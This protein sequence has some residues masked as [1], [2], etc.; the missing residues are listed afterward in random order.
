MLRGTGFASKPVGCLREKPTAVSLGDEPPHH[1]IDIGRSRADG[2]TSLHGSPQLA[3][4][5]GPDSCSTH[6]SE[7]PFENPVGLY[8]ET[9]LQGGARI[10]AVTCRRTTPCR[11]FKKPLCP[12]GKLLCCS[13]LRIAQPGYAG[14]IPQ[15][16]RFSTPQE[17]CHILGM[18][19]Q[20]QLCALSRFSSPLLRTASQSCSSLLL[21]TLSKI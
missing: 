10:L 17:S 8:L 20:L 21:S 4:S 12:A 16:A 6:G 5:Q 13:S 3:L 2:K 7:R 14:C 1:R 19:M 15:N 9:G 18:G 11:C